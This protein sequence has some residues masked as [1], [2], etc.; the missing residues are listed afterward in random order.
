MLTVCV[1]MYI[2]VCIISK[3]IVL[4]LVLKRREKIEY[5]KECHGIHE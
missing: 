3:V 5:T 4:H 2:S 1:S